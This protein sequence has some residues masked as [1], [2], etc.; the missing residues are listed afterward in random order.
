MKKLFIIALLTGIFTSVQAQEKILS[1][2]ADIQSS[3]LTFEYEVSAKS[4]ARVDLDFMFGEYNMI[5]LKPEYHFHKIN[6]A[7]DLGGSGNLVPYHGP[8]MVIGV[9]EDDTTFALEFVWGLE[10]DL[11]DVP[12]EV[13][14]DAGPNFQFEPV[15]VFTLTSSFGMRY[16]F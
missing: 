6:H 15:S 11:N 8:G 2:G 4:A 3:S 16:K 1:L 5:V 12:F 10:Y 13:F 9:G 14:M 7:M